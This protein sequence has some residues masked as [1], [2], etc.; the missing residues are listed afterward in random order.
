MGRKIRLVQ[1]GGWDELVRLRADKQSLIGGGRTVASC[2]GEG[3]A[4][5]QGFLG[6]RQKTAERASEAADS[7]HRPVR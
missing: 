3:S 2:R 7:R 5:Q 4:S 1:V 6:S